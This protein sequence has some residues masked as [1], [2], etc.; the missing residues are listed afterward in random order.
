VAEA[1]RLTPAELETRLARLPRYPLGAFPTPLQ[2]LPRLSQ[3]MGVRMLVKRDD[4]SGLAFG[5]NKVRQAEFFVGAALAAGCDMIIAGGNYAQSNHARIMSAAA[6]AAGLTPIII[7]RPGDKHP[8]GGNALVTTLLAEEVLVVDELATAS[9]DRLAEVDARRIAFER[10]AEGYRAR[11]RVP[12]VL[13]GSS[14]PLGAAGYLGASLELHG[15][16]AAAGIRPDWV[17]VT[18]TGAS[19]AGLELGRRLLGESHAVAGIAYEPTGDRAAEWVASLTNGLA[20]LL[21]LPTRIRA[22]SIVNS[23][24]AAGPAYGVPSPATIDAI[25]LLAEEEGLL[26]D[27]VYSAKGMAGL[28]DWIRGG[29]I[30]SGQTVVFMHTGGLPALFVYADQVLGTG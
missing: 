15:Q 8:E 27:P 12:Y 17:V 19:Q 9:R 13:P 24:A 11:G 7:V 2:E 18:S 23:D 21:D 30:R 10:V 25:R 6:R 4:L 14:I 1:R 28:L 3:R 26:L 22:A 20:R 29:R 5:G 16:F